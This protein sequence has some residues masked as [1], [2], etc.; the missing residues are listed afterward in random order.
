MRTTGHGYPAHCAAELAKDHKNILFIGNSHT[1]Y[2]DLPGMVASLAA[3]AGAGK[4]ED[5]ITLVSCRQE[6]RHHHGGSWGPD[7]DWSRVQW[8]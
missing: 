3:A 5:D 8:H 7:P 1:Y 4:R 6:R 2:H